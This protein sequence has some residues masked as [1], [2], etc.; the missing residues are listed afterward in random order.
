M[1]AKKSLGQNFLN[2]KGIIAKIAE[3]GKL[4]TGDTVV[5][6][7]PGQ[8]ALT[9]ALLATG[10][11]VVAI[12]KDDRLIS[13]LSEKFSS[14]IHTNNFIL[15]HG[16]VLEEQILQKV[17]GIIGEDSY[18]LIAN[19]PYYITGQIIRTFLESPKTPTEAILM[20]QKEV[21]NRI[22]TRDEKESILSISVKIFG[23][24]HL[25]THVSR[26]SFTP[27]PNVDSAVISIDNISNPFADLK[28]KD[29][30][31]DLVKTGF[32]H[33][34]KKLISNLE[35]KWGKEQLKSV[36]KLLDISENI[37]PEEITVG[38]WKEISRLM[39]NSL[40]QKNK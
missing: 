21:A 16:D 3:A 18:K 35:E 9:E 15:I 29:L 26:G 11:R 17:I 22:L 12:E 36:F 5:E 19:I 39:T 32:A 24:P 31:F 28:E 37:R 40:S 25:V 30:F 14:F 33:K 2:N 6:I 20:V 34:R 8:G 38:Q 23:A 4:N 13:F 10:A 27:A 7:G 1:F